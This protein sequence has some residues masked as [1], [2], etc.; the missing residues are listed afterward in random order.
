MLLKDNYKETLIN[1]RYRG[2][3]VLF[4]HL[5]NNVKYH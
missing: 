2:P 1:L 5:S 4:S 3:I